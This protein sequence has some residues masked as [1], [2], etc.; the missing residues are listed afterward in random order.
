ME[1]LQSACGYIRGQLG[2]RVNLRR[3]PEI[4]FAEDRSLE[5]GMRVI[6]LIEQLAQNRP[7]EGS[8]TETGAEVPD[9]EELEV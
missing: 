2:K 3:T 1:G 9:A 4:S 5:R 6:S 8:G 7:A